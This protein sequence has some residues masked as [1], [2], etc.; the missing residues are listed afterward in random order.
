MKIDLMFGVQLADVSTGYSG[1]PQGILHCF[2]IES[3][4][5]QCKTLLLVVNAST[6]G[7]IYKTMTLR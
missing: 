4:D 7:G 6:K 3:D 2:Y 1:H 5:K